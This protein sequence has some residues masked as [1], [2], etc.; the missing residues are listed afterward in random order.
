[1]KHYNFF[2]LAT[3][4]AASI[5]LA[6]CSCGK[7]DDEPGDSASG[8]GLV[9][10]GEKSGKVY[11]A[12]CFSYNWS[13]EMGGDATTSF[14]LKFDCGGDMTMFDV[15]WTMERSQIK[16]GMDLME[17]DTPEYVTFRSVM[18][19]DIDPRYEDFSGRVYVE[20]VTGKAITLRFDNFSFNKSPGNRS[21]SINGKMTYAIN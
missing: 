2:M 12:E 9:V 21:Y 10:N 8:S 7:D 13:E 17:Y 20:S 5:I 4:L 16:A 14:E 15:A 1:M 6:L 19:I 11:N 3:I 18:T